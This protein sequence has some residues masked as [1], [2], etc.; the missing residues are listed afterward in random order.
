MWADW[1]QIGSCG[2]CGFINVPSSFELERVRY[3]SITIS[4]I[5]VTCLQAT[6][7]ARQQ[8]ARPARKPAIQPAS[9]RAARQSASQPETGIPTPTRTTGISFCWRLANP[10]R[11]NQSM[12]PSGDWKKHSGQEIL[13]QTKLWSGNSIWTKFCFQHQTWTKFGFKTKINPN[14]D[15]KPNLD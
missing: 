15:L 1:I 10:Q 6:S 3:S 2:F 7:S 13:M 12:R 4:T 5:T 8:P 9:Q 11:T 14:L